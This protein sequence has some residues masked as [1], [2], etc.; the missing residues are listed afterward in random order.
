MSVNFDK[1]PDKNPGGATAAPGFYKFTVTKAEMRQ[2]KDLTKPPYLSMTYGLN[3]ITGKKYGNMF[4]SQ[5]DS[6]AEIMQFKLQ[7]FANAIGLKLKGSVDLKDLAKL[8]VN[9]SGVVEVE[10]V[11]NYKDA[12]RMDA[13]TRLFG[14]DCY[15][16]LSEFATLVS[17]AAPDMSTP[18]A[19]AAFEF[20]DDDAP[21]PQVGDAVPDVSSEY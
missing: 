3:D 1:L 11:P 8:V 14:S 6:P 18:D 9:R 4:D 13:S 21:V 19:D 17:G 16:P 7:R 10:N 20:S 5:Y 12:T 2:P 15:W